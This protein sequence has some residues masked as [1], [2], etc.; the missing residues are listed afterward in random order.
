MSPLKAIQ[1]LENVPDELK[2][3]SS[4]VR[5]STDSEGRKIPKPS[6]DETLLSFEDVKDIPITSTSGIGFVFLKQNE[7]CGIDLDSCL[8][9]KTG[10]LTDWAEKIVKE[11][12]SYCE[13]SP[14]GTGVKIFIK[15]PSPEE[16]KHKVAMPGKPTG[17]HA[18]QIEA[19][20]QK[21]YFCT[22]G[23]LFRDSPK[24]IKRAPKEW[25]ALLRFMEDNQP[26]DKTTGKVKKDAT[27]RDDYIYKRACSRQAL[28]W[29]DDEIYND[30]IKEDAKADPSNHPNYSTEGPLGEKIVREKVA[31]ALKFPKGKTVLTEDSAFKSMNEE[32]AVS[33][34]GADVVVLREHVDPISKRNTV[35]FVE[36]RAMK[37]MLANKFIF[38]AGKT[39]PLFDYWLSNPQRREFR[40]IVFEPNTPT[41]GDFNLWRGWAVEPDPRG[42]EGCKLFLFHLKD[43]LCD[44]NEAHYQWA[45][46]WMAQAVQE[47]GKRPGTTIVLKSGEGA[48]KGIEIEYFGRLWGQHFLHLADQQRLTGRFNDHLKDA[49]LVYGDEVFFGGDRQAANILKSIITDE[50][51]A[52]EPKFKSVLQV[53]NHIRLVLATNEEW[54]IPTGL[55]ARRFFMPK[56]SD[57]RRDDSAYFQALADEMNTGGPGALLHYLQHLEI[58]DINLRNPPKTETLLEQKHMSLNPAQRFWF[59]RLIEGEPMENQFDREGW[60]TYQLNGSWIKPGEG[61]IRI[62]KKAFYQS[63][64][65]G[66]KDANDRYRSS[67]EIFWHQIKKLLPFDADISYSKSQ[68]KKITP[69]PDPT[70][71]PS[72]EIRWERAAV[73]P[74]LVECR[75]AFESAI[76]QKVAWPLEPAEENSHL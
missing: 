72:I 68:F 5:W 43:I 2:A 41:P 34:A 6:I 1:Y 39:R 7:Y 42:E 27:G 19:Y 65:D 56:V 33:W 12:D 14:S 49:L 8:D 30:C 13:I 26:K 61:E 73:I 59:E 37:L 62:R 28:G 11:F 46:A 29:P 25:D 44:G 52:I 35:S 67:P 64:I 66:C 9:P 36:P 48:G 40:Q 58:K 47:P 70:K 22:T 4:W 23:N 17:K 38:I 10:N 45:L 21:R 3:F 20:S 16:H 51:L 74:N 18:C 60:E 76:R 15:A 63:Y 31:S 57:K 54:A 71:S 32:Y 50:T 69:D 55:D 24:I 53:R 75:Q